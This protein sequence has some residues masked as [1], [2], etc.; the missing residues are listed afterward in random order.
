MAPERILPEILVFVLGL[1]VGSFLNVL[2]LRTLEGKSIVW[3]PSACSGCGKRIAAFD[4]VPVLSFL[5]LKGRCRACQAPISWQYPLVELTTAVALVAV[6]STFGFT[7]YALGMAVFVCTLIAVTVTDFREKLIPHDIT[8][9]SMLIGIGFSAYVRNDL[10]GAMAGVGAS[11]IIF[12]FLAHYG[13]KLYMAVYASKDKDSAAEPSDPVLDGALDLPGEEA[14]AREMDE[15]EVMGGG[16]AVLSAVISAWLGWQRLVVA[17]L[18]GFVV[19]TVMGT[20]YLI[21]EMRKANILHQCY[22]PA[23]AGAILGFALLSLPL[24]V[25]GLSMGLSLGELPWPYLGASGAMAGCLLGIVSVGTKVSKPFPFGPA[26]A[27]GGAAAIF[28]NPL[29]GVWTGGA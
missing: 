12:D 13:L 21:A 4:N 5:L 15:F 3:P 23:A 10:L 26:L 16:D 7:M 2:A 20:I 27:A 28:W 6:T 14:S 9:P 24:I 11:Y 29:G 19:G 18:V 22:R 17:L 1:C 8:Y 25:V